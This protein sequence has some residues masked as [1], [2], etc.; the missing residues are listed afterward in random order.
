MEAWVQKKVLIVPPVFKKYFSTI[1]GET[2]AC[3]GWSL[4]TQAKT[5]FILGHYGL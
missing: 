3:S 1:T 5:N 4:K 2:K